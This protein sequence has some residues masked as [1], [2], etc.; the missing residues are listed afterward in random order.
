MSNIPTNVWPI[1]ELF[2]KLK[3]LK[4]ISH[5]SGVGCGMKFILKSEGI[6]EAE[7]GNLNMDTLRHADAFEVG[8]IMVGGK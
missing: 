3:R 6:P 2:R 5:I 8:L 4:P 1:C 7:A